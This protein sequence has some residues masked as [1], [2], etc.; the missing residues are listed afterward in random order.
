MDKAIRLRDLIKALQKIEAEDIVGGGRLVWLEG[1]HDGPG[2]CTG[3][4]IWSDGALVL[5]RR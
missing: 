1:Q 2:V 3:V 5:E 4:A